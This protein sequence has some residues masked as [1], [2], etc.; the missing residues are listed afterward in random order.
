M[1]DVPAAILA[2]IPEEVR[3]VR[4]GGVLLKGLD[5]VSGDV[6]D[7]ELR[8]GETV[9]VGRVEVDLGECR[10]FEDNP[11][12]EGFAWLTIR[13]SVRDAVVFDGWMIA[14]SPALN[15]LDHPR[16]DVWVIR[17]TTA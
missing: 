4:S 6:I 17:C 7:V 11:A 15:A 5:K 13:D 8:V 16:Y 3:V 2:A 10:Y 12:G 9:T 1:D 14:S